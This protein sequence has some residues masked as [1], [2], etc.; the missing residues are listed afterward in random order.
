MAKICENIEHDNLRMP[1]WLLFLRAFRAAF[2]RTKLWL[3]TWFVLLLLT[4]IPA[5]QTA[6]FFDRTV[7]SRYPSAE[8]AKDLHATMSPPSTGL[9]AVFRQDHSDG[10]AQLSDGLSSSG[11]ILALIAFLFGVFAAGGWLQITFEQPERQTLR[12]FGFGGARY[13]GR[14]FRVALITLGALALVHWVFYGD[15]WKRLVLGEI[16]GPSD[17]LLFTE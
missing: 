3:A 17:G 15:P 16:S 9:N 11:A 14:L 4:L 2:V 7:G 12:R 5:M 8:A 13:F 6:S 1:D 10:L